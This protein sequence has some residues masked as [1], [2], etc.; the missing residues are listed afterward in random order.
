MRVTRLFATALFVLYLT[1]MRHAPSA[2]GNE[3]GYGSCSDLGGLGFCFQVGACYGV[4]FQGYL[5]VCEELECYFSPY[6]ECNT[7]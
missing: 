7:F 1:T 3:C 6:D 4:N 5:C 2:E